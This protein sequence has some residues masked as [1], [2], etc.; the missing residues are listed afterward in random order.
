MPRSPSEKLAALVTSTL[1]CVD[2][3]GTGDVRLRDVAG[4]AGVSKTWIL[5][6]YPS[7]SALIAF[8]IG[9]RFSKRVERSIDLLTRLA[10]E[11]DSA[12]AFIS[13]IETARGQG[14]HVLER[15]E[16]W[17]F[18]E[19]LVWSIHDV[20]V[21]G[22]L[23]K[24][25]K[26]LVGAYERLTTTLDDRGWLHPDVGP[27]SAA[28]FLMA[29]SLARVRLG[30]QEV[31]PDGR[32]ESLLLVTLNA[33]LVQHDTE[34]QWSGLVPGDERSRVEDQLARHEIAGDMV[35]ER[36]LEAAAEE[37]AERGALEF[38][39]RA[40]MDA[41]Q[42]STT[43]IYKHFGNREALVEYAA[44][45]LKRMNARSVRESLTTAL[46]PVVSVIDGPRRDRMV[47]AVDAAYRSLRFDTPEAFKV[48][49]TAL[50]S[51]RRVESDDDSQ[52]RRREYYETVAKVFI[53]QLELPESFDPRAYADI[54]PLAFFTG[55]VL[56]SF[57]EDLAS[58]ISLGAGI[59]RVV[60]STMSLK[61]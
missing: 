40:V 53:H 31:P 5:S 2:S 12:D 61:E 57:P 20:E 24:A 43:L 38:R 47:H 25:K 6:V 18:F 35:R 44:V 27:V 14:D 42:V 28:V 51:G 55:V 16:V 50:V 58:E 54:G 23:A 15:E 1:E 17:Q 3:R 9:D 52:R 30:S 33:L 48:G 34:V 10:V 22:E 49:L 60:E 36:I 37:L 45:R 21:A 39:I 29:S 4:R 13:T 46:E 8:A 7:R 26:R 41:A 56:V 59:I 19:V 32:E 11:L